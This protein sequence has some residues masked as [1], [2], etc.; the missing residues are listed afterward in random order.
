MNVE[1]LNFLLFLMLGRF[2]VMVMIVVNK[3]INMVMNM[4]DGFYLYESFNVVCVV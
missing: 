3:V 2:F 4:M 1:M